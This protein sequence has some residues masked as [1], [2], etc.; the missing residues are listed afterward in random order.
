M[1]KPLKTTNKRMNKLLRKAEGCGW[2]LVQSGSGHIK[3]YSPDGKTIS[4]VSVTPRSDRA[5]EAAK[6][7]FRKGG[8]NI[9]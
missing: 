3:C 7:I 6:S 5:V 8:L 4:V 1:S 2:K 9:E